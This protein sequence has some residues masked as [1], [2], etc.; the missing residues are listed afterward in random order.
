MGKPLTNKNLEAKDKVSINPNITIVKKQIVYSR[1]ASVRSNATAYPTTMHGGSNKVVKLIRDDI[2][3]SQYLDT[4]R[5]MAISSAIKGVNN[6]NYVRK[7]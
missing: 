5:S 4:S 1:H 6:A 2:D 7:I 3:S